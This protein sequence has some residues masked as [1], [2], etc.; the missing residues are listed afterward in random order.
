MRAT[1]KTCRFKFAS[2]CRRYPPVFV[3]TTGF[4]ATESFQFPQ[5]EDHNWCGEH[6]ERDDGR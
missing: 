2:Q 4:L 3:G 6:K 1:C 5:V